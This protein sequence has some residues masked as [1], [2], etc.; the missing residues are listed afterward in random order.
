MHT[1]HNTTRSDDLDFRNATKT[2]PDL[3]I[4]YSASVDLLSCQ[5]CLTFQLLR[6]LRTIGQHNEDGAAISCF[7]IDAI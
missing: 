6:P 7:P 4:P 5:H 3:N 2:D 1:L